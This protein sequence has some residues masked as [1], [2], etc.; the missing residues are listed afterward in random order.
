MVVMVNWTQVLDLKEL[1]Y[2][3]KNRYIL[4]QYDPRKSEYSSRPPA[5]L[6]TGLAEDISELGFEG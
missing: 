2:R 4:G 1:S 6:G 5:M 3:K